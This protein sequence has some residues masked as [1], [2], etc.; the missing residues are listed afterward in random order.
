MEK[1]KYLAC[2]WPPAAEVRLPNG[3]PVIGRRLGRILD[4][5]FKKLIPDGGALPVDVADTGAA[6]F[7]AAYL[8]DL[9]AGGR[10]G[11][12]AALLA[13]DFAPL[14][15]ICRF[16]RFVNLTPAEQDLYLHD[17]YASR[18]YF[19]RMFVVLLKTLTGMGFYND[20][21]VLEF[22]R[23]KLPCGDRNLP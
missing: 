18:I 19:R 15:F 6:R 5:L 8:R 12:K 10:V 17:W 21:K 16:S 20:P 23:Y 3:K 22:L 11:L 2:A 7:L 13:F 9:P 4:A 1:D 14:L